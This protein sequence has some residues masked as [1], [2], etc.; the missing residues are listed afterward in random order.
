MHKLM[1]L[2]QNQNLVNNNGRQK[3]FYN[4]LQYSKIQI[5][6]ERLYLWKKGRLHPLLY[7][8]WLTQTSSENSI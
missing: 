2:D 6:H 4:I 1:S 8:I 5:L 3:L 7:Y